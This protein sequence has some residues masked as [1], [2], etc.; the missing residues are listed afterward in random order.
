MRRPSKPR[1]EAA[2]DLDA[3]RPDLQKVIDRHAPTLD[4]NR[5]AAV[6]KRHAQGG[7]TARENIADLCDLPTTPATSSNTARWPSPRRR[8]AARS[9]T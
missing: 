5:A 4:A 2:H 9:R 6:A 3:I 7:R 1:R 8:A